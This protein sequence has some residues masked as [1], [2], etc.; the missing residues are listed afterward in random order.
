M[1]REDDRPE[2]ARPPRV[3]DRGLDGGGHRAVRDRD[4]V[5]PGGQGQPRRR[6]RADRARARPG[7]SAPTSRR[8]RAATATN[9]E[10]KRDRKLLLH[11]EPD[12]PAPRQDEGQGPD[13]RSRSSSTSP[14][15]ARRSSSSGSARA[16]SCYDRR[17][18]IA[19][20][21]TPSARSSASWRTPAAAEPGPP[22][23]DSP[24]DA[25]SWRAPSARAD[26]PSL[27]PTSRLSGTSGSARR[28]GARRGRQP[29]MDHR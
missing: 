7:W 29:S 16:S 4:Q 20:R 8:G 5:D 18:E 17:R 13:A 22:R 28:R 11:R 6:V 15:A 19:G 10:P 14:R 26:R 2:P 24:A 3:L 9:H 25:T 1:S 27:A 21:A 23:A 12:R